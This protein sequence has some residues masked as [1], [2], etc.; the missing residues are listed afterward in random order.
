MPMYNLTQDIHNTQ[1]ATSHTHTYIYIHSHSS[2]AFVHFFTFSLFSV[3][4]QQLDLLA[5]EDL[6]ARRLGGR[7]QLGPVDLADGILVVV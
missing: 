3:D 6:L 4:E 5:Q 1:H 7:G 2:H